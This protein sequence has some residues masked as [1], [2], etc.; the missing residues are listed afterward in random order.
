[1]WGR[2]EGSTDVRSRGYPA[3]FSIQRL[4]SVACARQSYRLY[5][6]R[7][8]ARV[9]DIDADGTSYAVCRSAEVRTPQFGR[10]NHL[11]PHRPG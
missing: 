9:F 6:L 7:L 4:P 5:P 3:K 2:L 1:M 10:H 8:A 11:E